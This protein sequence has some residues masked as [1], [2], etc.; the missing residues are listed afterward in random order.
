MSIIL[1]GIIV[2]VVLALL[3]RHLCFDADYDAIRKHEAA[4]QAWQKLLEEQ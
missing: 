1:F 2:L 3:I 4:K